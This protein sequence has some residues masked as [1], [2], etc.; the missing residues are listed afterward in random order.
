MNEKSK[1]QLEL[2][3]LEYKV[4]ELIKT[5]EMLSTENQKLKHLSDN[6]SVERLSLIEKT[7]QARRRV[8]AMITRLKAMENR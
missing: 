1:N 6:L 8:E 4:D 7:E 5:V 2:T 3:S